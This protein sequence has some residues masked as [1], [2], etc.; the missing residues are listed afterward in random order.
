[1]GLK[2]Q[3]TRR[4]GSKITTLI[5][6]FALVMQ[7]MYGLVEDALAYT[8]PSTND[9]NMTTNTKGRQW[10]NVQLVEARPGE[11][12]LKFTNQLT[13]WNCFEYRIDGTLQGTHLTSKVQRSMID[14]HNVIM[15]DTVY[16]QICLRDTADSQPT[17]THTFTANEKVEVRMALGPERM[18]DFNW[19]TFNSLPIPDTTKPTVEI[20][21]PSSNSFDSQNTSLIFK[22]SDDKALD[23]VVANFR[24]AGSNTVIRSTQS[25]ANGTT[26]F[27]HVTDL[28]NYPE[29]LAPGDYTVRY[30]AIDEAGNLSDTKNYAFSVVDKIKPVTILIKPEVISQK[31]STIDIEV[32]ATDERGLKKIV[33]NIYKDGALH[34]ST[35][36]AML[37]EK[38]GTHTASINLDEGA[39]SIKY[40]SEDN[41]GNI[42]ETRT[43]TITIDTTA[44]AFSIE[45]PTNGQH[46]SGTIVLD[47]KIT[48]DSDIT[49]VLMNIGGISRSWTNGSSSTITRT[50]DVFST[51][52][53][54]SM[55]PEGP[56]YVTLRGTDGAG[57]TRYW[58]N[59]AKSRQH[60]FYVDRTAP[61]ITRWVVGG[62]NYASPYTL[63]EGQ[64]FNSKN[65]NVQFKDNSKLAKVVINDHEIVG[66]WSDQKSFDAQ[67]YMNQYAKEGSNTIA[68][69]DEAGNK[70]TYAFVID[71]V[72]PVVT[73]DSPAASSTVK[74]GTDIKATIVDG[75]LS[76]YYL[77]VK[78][79][80]DSSQPWTELYKKTITSEEFAGDVLY[81]LPSNVSGEV[82]V[83]LDAKD[84]A[85]NKDEND[86]V[87]KIFFI[88]DNSAPTASISLNSLLNPTLATVGISDTHSPQGEYVVNVLP[89]SGPGSWRLCGLTSFALGE[90]SADC[91]MLSTLLDGTYYL[92]ANVFDA[93]GNNSAGVMPG[94][95]AISDEFIIDTTRPIVTIDSVNL[96]GDLLEVTVSGKDALSGLLA[97]G[98]NI[99]D[100]NNEG[101]ALVSGLGRIKDNIAKGTL[102][103][104]VVRSDIDISALT[105][106]TYTIRAVALDHAGLYSTQAL[107]Q[108]TVDRTAPVIAITS[109]TPSLITGTVG[110]DAEKV[111]VRV[112]DQPEQEATIGEDGKT[113]TLAISPALTASTTVTA[114]AVDAANNTNSAS[115][116]PKWATGTI[117]VRTPVT[118]GPLES[119]NDAPSQ[120]GSSAILA[121][122]APTLQVTNPVTD[123]TDETGDAAGA[124]TVNKDSEDKGQVLAAEDAKD[125]WSLINLL[126]TI[127][128]GVASIISL[129]GLLGANRKDRKLASRLLTIVPAAGAVVALL[130][131][132]DFSGS[133]IWVNTWSLLIG[134]LAV[135]Q[136]II[137]GMSKATTNE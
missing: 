50:D 103:D 40:N 107:G 45:S 75:N 77:L 129:L 35:Q 100:A 67:W 4:I 61:T 119:R 124:T 87:K 46:V 64:L 131:I 91:V 110:A 33:A 42:S 8:F 20:V 120:G 71:S 54:T 80:A 98:I 74:G 78:I 14:K 86:S 11:V 60:V 89:A 9:K 118:N 134:A 73:I 55:L 93:V 1:M 26:T 15:G 132:E 88:L 39:Y 90:T 37:G 32:A 109:A 56:V 12:E 25:A 125:S 83:Q 19:V 115:T 106:G 6:V 76:H 123:T 62:K 94:G 34:K 114:R 52:V 137:L 128:I 51:T 5:A 22:A 21:A 13:Y 3:P 23:K 130:L 41:S 84:K 66:K 38:S 31:S 2:I 101:D 116:N 95:A 104:S 72:A 63:T 108:F 127:G 48:D 135:V 28:K 82:Y 126:L 117:Y 59:N 27:E 69:Y 17:L 7:P 81:T 99:Y 29:L 49:K 18:H 65:I 47:A 136:M 97:L 30:N 113:W 57:N 53:D 122:T 105:D 43:H 102:S 121:N 92:R 58:N 16:P 111:L 36:T 68:L 10:P 112:G 44:P 24:K 96:T 79:R 85:G 133:M 70:A